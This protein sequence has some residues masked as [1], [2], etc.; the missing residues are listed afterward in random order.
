MSVLTARGAGVRRRRQWLFRDLDV[1][2]EPGETVAVVGPPGSGR[3]TVLLAL[4]RRFRLSAGRVAVDGA[5]ALGHVPEVSAPEPVFTVAEH[6]R[7]RLALL[8]RPLAEAAGVP[9]RGLP[10]GRRGSELT[11]YEK[12]VLGLILAGLGDPAVIALDGVDDGLDAAE[13]AELWRLLDEIAAAGT[14]VLVTAREIDAA[15][16]SAVI[17]LGTEP[18]IESAAPREA[19]VRAEVV[20]DPLGEPPPRELERA[21][22]EGEPPV[23]LRVQEPDESGAPEP[24]STEPEAEVQRAEAEVQT[25]EAEVQTAEAVVGN[26][27]RR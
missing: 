6:V 15:R 8:G 16:V 13:Q 18:R 7:E 4:A 19:K 5:A 25:A 10:P 14:A 20:A 3:T 24:E 2:V 27:E 26:G 12:Q 23:E 1:T 22:A 17:R 21:E 11:P 9:L